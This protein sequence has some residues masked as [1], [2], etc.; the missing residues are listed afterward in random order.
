MSDDKPRIPRRKPPQA[1]QPARSHQPLI[2]TMGP[3]ISSVLWSASVVVQT[4][5]ILTVEVVDGEIRWLK[6]IH[7]D[8]LRVGLPISGK[9]GEVVVG[10]MSWFP[11]T[12]RVAHSTSWRYEEGRVILTYIVV[13]E[14]PE[15]LAPNSL[16]VI[17]VVRANIARGE[18]MA[19]PTAIDVNAVLEHALRHLAWLVKDDATIAAA[20]PDWLAVLSAYTPEP[21]RAL[22]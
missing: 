10:V 12:P 4:L 19:P 13:V 20:L 18:A 11:L 15:S 7:A 9:P 17:P 5:E 16:V 14:P 21:F 8:S 1:Q 6:P 3:P 2:E 22:G